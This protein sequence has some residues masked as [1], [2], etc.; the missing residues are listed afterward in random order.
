MLL[1][2]PAEMPA[3]RGSIQVLDLQGGN[4]SVVLRSAD[5]ATAAAAV[6]RVLA[7]DA[8]PTAGESGSADSSASAGPLSDVT[9]GSS[10]EEDPFAVGV[11]IAGTVGHSV[12][13]V[14][15]SGD[16]ANRPSI[17]GSRRLI[18][19]RTPRLSSQRRTAR[20]SQR[21]TLSIS[22][23]TSKADTLLQSI[24]PLTPCR[25]SARIAVSPD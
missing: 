20:H 22:S 16:C 9:V 3:L 21:T 8:A 5:A 4:G 10:G 15:R 25:C 11:A 1:C 12:L 24:S 7:V 23:A 2:F 18:A 6:A 13:P 14:L 19:R 17:R